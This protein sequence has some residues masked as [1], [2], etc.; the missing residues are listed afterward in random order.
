MSG[1]ARVL[2]NGSRI[3]R[4]FVSGPLLGQRSCVKGMRAS[5]LAVAFVACGPSAADVSWA[6]DPRF[7]TDANPPTSIS[8]VV[9]AL[10]VGDDCITA[11]TATQTLGASLREIDP[12][13]WAVT[14]GPGVKADDCV[15]PITDVA[16][17]Q[18][19]LT[20]ALRPEV[21]VALERVADELLERCLGRD[22][23]A[24]L[25]RS[26]LA[27]LDGSDWQL[28]DDGPIGGPIDRLEE[29][30]RHVEAGCFIYSGTG[31]TP[32]GHRLYFIGGR[33]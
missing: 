8:E 28:R 7:T 6:D 5:I 11:E 24:Q 31:L 27:D 3:A 2:A 21:R 12:P 17:Q 10:W 26:T 25:V 9:E 14:L 32:E 20:Q 22:D 33:E 29:I 30:K 19:R 4:A 15:A 16:S 23:A 13:G 1:R 18:I